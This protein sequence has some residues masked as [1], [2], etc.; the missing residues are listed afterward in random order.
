MVSVDWSLTT[1][2][3]L[4]RYLGGVEI[5]RWVKLVRLRTG[6]PSHAPA[7]SKQLQGMRQARQWNPRASLNT[8][9]LKGRPIP[10][11]SIRTFAVRVLGVF[12][13]AQLIRTFLCHN[14]TLIFEHKKATH[15]LGFAATCGIAMP[16]FIFNFRTSPILHVMVCHV[17]FFC[18]DV[19]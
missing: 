6:S 19:C 5:C 4:H 14:P 11:P 15:F 18:F 2:R 10:P 7:G 16:R 3:A 12:L 9:N 1:R 8:A 13:F 17:V